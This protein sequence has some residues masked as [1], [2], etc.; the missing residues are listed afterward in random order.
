MRIAQTRQ[1]GFRVTGP[2]GYARNIVWKNTNRL[3]PIRGYE[4]IKTGTTR[5]AG[6][7]LV[8]SA[9]RGDDQLIVAVLGAQSS[10]ARYVDARNLY[11]WAWLQLGHED[12]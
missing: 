5:A 10:D 6:A 11:R 2:G 3:L 7:C 12:E 8:S 1:R 4:G 9:R